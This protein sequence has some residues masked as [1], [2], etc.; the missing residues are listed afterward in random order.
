MALADRIVLTKSDLADA[1]A[2]GE[3]TQRIAGLTRPRS[4]IADKGAIAPAFIFDEPPPRV[5]AS[6]SASASTIMATRTP[7]ASKA[8]R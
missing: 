6:S 8:F 3:L 7:T 4:S 1:A 5:S 2:I